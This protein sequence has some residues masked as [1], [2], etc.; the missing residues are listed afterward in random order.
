MKVA[1]Q[2]LVFATWGALGLGIYSYKSG[3]S[4]AKSIEPKINASS[5]SEEQFIQE[6]L[7]A[8]E[9]KPSQAKH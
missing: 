8:A 5:P 4:S 1:S 2:Y 9:S 6:F 7:K 3:K